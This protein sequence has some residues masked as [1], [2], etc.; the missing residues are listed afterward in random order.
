MNNFTKTILSDFYKTQHLKKRNN[1]G[2]KNH[3]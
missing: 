2:E 3:Y 1:E